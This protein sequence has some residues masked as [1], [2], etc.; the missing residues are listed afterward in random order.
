MVY[1]CCAKGR[2]KGSAPA[3]SKVQN[4]AVAA[5]PALD[6]ACCLRLALSETV[7][8]YRAPPRP[9]RASSAAAASQNAGDPQRRGEGPWALAHWD[10]RVPCLLASIGS[11]D[12]GPRR[13]R[14]DPPPPPP[15]PPRPHSAPWRPGAPA[16][17]PWWPTSACR[18]RPRCAGARA[19][20]GR[21]RAAVRRSPPLA[22]SPAAT[23]RQRSRG[24]EPRA[25]AVAAAVPPCFAKQLRAGG[26]ARQPC[27]WLRTAMQAAR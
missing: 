6:R 25:A 2:G 21:R 8:P 3:P 22:P 5:P 14:P 17:C 20:A 24:A 23:C 12:G 19:R 27:T 16:P 13:A 1:A 4:S 15:R 26:A 18:R 9:A 7:V 11:D 10:G